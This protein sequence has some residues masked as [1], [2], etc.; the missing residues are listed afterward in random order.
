VAISHASLTVPFVL[1]A[2]LALLLYPQFSESDVPFTSFALFVGVA[3]SITAFP[4]LARILAD[5]RIQQT[6]L[7]ILAL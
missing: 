4:V 7:G 2:A 3:L 5:R 1:G 6:R